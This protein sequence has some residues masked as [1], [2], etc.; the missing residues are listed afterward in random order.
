MVANWRIHL[1]VGMFDF[2]ELPLVIYENGAL[3]LKN[4]VRGADSWCIVKGTLYT[5]LVWLG[6]VVESLLGVRRTGFSS[7]PSFGIYEI[8]GAITKITQFI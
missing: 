7:S 3:L 6:L 5:M 4:Q 8:Y 1:V 2:R